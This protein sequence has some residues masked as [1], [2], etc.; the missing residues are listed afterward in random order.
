MKV[1][2]SNLNLDAGTNGSMPVSQDSTPMP[3][4]TVAGQRNP[5]QCMS[6]C[7]PKVVCG[8]IGSRIVSGEAHFRHDSSALTDVWL[9]GFQACLPN[10]ERCHRRE[11][12]SLE[13]VLT[14][15]YQL[16]MTIFSLGN[17]KK[18][19]LKYANQQQGNEQLR[20]APR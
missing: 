8:L 3:K 7:L 9:V 13:A 15:T 12:S 6:A 18:S 19:A 20:L 10:P 4:R 1:C 2:P 11:N 17:P 14:Y 5:I 16:P